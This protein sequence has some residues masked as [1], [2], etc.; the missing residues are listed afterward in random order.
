MYSKR[1]RC[2]LSTLANCT[3]A[4]ER[5]VLLQTVPD[6]IVKVLTEIVKNLFTGSIPLSKRNYNRLKRYNTV[7]EDVNAN[8]AKKHRRALL[9]QKGGGFLP[10]LIPLVTGIVGRLLL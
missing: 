10:L 6:D 8:R 4:R 5:R 9:L 2:Y 1:Q 3:N 7:L